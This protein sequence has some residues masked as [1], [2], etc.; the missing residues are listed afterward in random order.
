M[1]LFVAKLSSS[2]TG[3]DL[4]ELFSAHGEV[5]S[6]KVIVDRE[7]GNSKGFGFVEMANDDEAKA[8]IAAINETE[9]DGKQIVV[10]EANDREER[11]RRDS[12]Q[13]SGGYQSR[14]GGGGGYQ[15]RS[16]GSG[17][18]GYQRR[19]DNRGGGGG[20]RDDNRGGGGPRREGGG[21]GGNRW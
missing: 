13:R 2:T 21:G 10:K 11:P 18:G 20:R 8:A 15:G 5:T 7:T 14:G 3:D 9:L 12:N 1:N 16:G 6:A 19:D 4:Q 17:G